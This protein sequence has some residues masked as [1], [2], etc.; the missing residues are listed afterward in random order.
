LNNGFEKENSFYFFIFGIFSSFILLTKLNY[1]VGF[2]IISIFYLIKNFK[3]NKKI[4]KEI[5]FYFLGF[6]IGCTPFILYD[7]NGRGFL[8]YFIEYLRLSM[9]Y[10]GMAVSDTLLIYFFLII[11]LIPICL[12]SNFYFNKNNNYLY[13]IAFFIPTIATIF[14]SKR[15]YN[16]YIYLCIPFFVIF[17][18]SL[19]NIL[20][21]INIFK[22]LILIPFSIFVFYIG[23]FTT[24]NNKTFYKDID[25]FY[26]Y[27]F[28]EDYKDVVDK[29][30]VIISFLKIENI[31]LDYFDCQPNYKYSFSVNIDYDN[32]KEVYDDYYNLIE[33]KEADFIILKRNKDNQI[34]ISNL[35]IN[36]EYL[37]KIKYKLEENYHKDNCYEYN[38][39]YYEVY[40]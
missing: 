9:E 23:F 28:Y 39:F 31:V 33:S 16:Y 27:K 20:D 18:I 19:K 12:L 8:D 15:F 32:F 6:I 38:N 34:I 4:L 13:L 30:S 17:F 29:D 11:F 25:N 37:D 5:I 3:N 26:S 10:V 36:K 24:Y 2:G 21:K 7:F 22:Y 40:R 1:L 14:I 35:L